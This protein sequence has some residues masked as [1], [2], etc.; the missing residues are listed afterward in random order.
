MDDLYILSYICEDYSEKEVSFTAE[1]EEEAKQLAFSCIK[2][3]EGLISS[4][5]L[6]NGITRWIFEYS[7]CVWHIDE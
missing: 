2:G 5:D 3:G 4:I 6:S 7:D 1:T